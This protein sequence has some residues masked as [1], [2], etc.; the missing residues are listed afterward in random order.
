MPS[1]FKFARYMKR[2]T[3]PSAVGTSDSSQFNA[4]DILEKSIA[5]SSSNR[6][7]KLTGSNSAG[8]MPTGP[9]PSLLEISVICV[10]RAGG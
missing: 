10:C 3:S 5:L 7:D 4:A 6:L 9:A 8:G 2:M 1:S